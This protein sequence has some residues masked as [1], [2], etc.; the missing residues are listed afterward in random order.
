M[1]PTASPD[2]PAPRASSASSTSCS[3]AASRACASVTLSATGASA[4]GA[5]RCRSSASRCSSCGMPRPQLGDPRRERLE[6]LRRGVLQVAQPGEGLGLLVQPRVGRRGQPQHLAEH[7]PGGR[8]V[9]RDV[10]VQLLAQRE[11][12]RELVP[13]RRQR[14]VEAGDGLLAVLRRGRSRGRAAR[15]SSPRRARAARCWPGPAAAR[16]SH[17]RTG[18][19]S[20]AATVGGGSA[21]RL[22]RRDAGHQ[23]GAA[24]DHGD[25][26]DDEERATAV[27]TR[28]WSRRPR[29]RCRSRPRCAGCR[30]RRPPRR[31]SHPRRTPA[32]RP[33]PARCSSSDSDSGE[34][35]RPVEAV[36]PVDRP[37][38]RSSR[39][40]RRA[41]TARRSTAVQVFPEA[42]SKLST[43]TTNSCV[44]SSVAQL[45]PARRRPATRCR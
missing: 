29:R 2:R 4:D 1:S 10:V 18:R 11:R 21:S 16:W 26:T 34:S 38:R 43:K 28:S 45:A 5:N 3:A 35:S 17:R 27:R 22:R 25:T 14:R 31:R 32:P 13:R 24:A 9:L 8:L 44:P 12:A 7:L 33:R 15:S 36:R 37:R 39:R 19:A 42:P 23:V 6:H 30:R 20:P 40:C 41:P